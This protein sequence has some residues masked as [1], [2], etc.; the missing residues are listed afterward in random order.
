MFLRWFSQGYSNFFFLLL[1]HVCIE[2]ECFSRRF[3]LFLLFILFKCFSLKCHFSHIENEYQICRKC[4]IKCKENKI[5]K[6]VG[7]RDSKREKERGICDRSSL[8]ILQLGNFIVNPF[9]LPN[10]LLLLALAAEIFDLYCILLHASASDDV[11]PH[12]SSFAIF[13]CVT[14]NDF[15]EN[16]RFLKWNA[17]GIVH[18]NHESLFKILGR[19]TADITLSSTIVSKMYT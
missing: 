14:M 19:I 11:F 5:N 2:V 18:A 4:C 10:S 17:L 3:Y 7:L 13:V 1:L 16:Y 6:C 8:S 12:F 15:I 9:F